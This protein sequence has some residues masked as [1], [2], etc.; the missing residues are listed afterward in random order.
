M[1]F[2]KLDTGIL[3]STLWVERECRELFITALLMAEPHE[4]LSDVPQIA[5]R[6]LEP[7]GWTVP[8]GWYGFIAAAGVGIIRRAIMEQ[9]LGMTAL[10]RLCA[11]DPE[12]RS[13][14]FEGR[15]LA[16]VDGGY[17]VLNYMKYRERDYTSAERQ[18]RYRLRKMGNV[19]PVAREDTPLR[20]NI[21]QA[22][23]EV[24]V[25]KVKSKGARKRATPL[26]EDFKISD[27]VKTW[28]L[29]KG[30]AGYLPAYFEFFIG[31]MSANG[32]TYVDW[33]QAFMNCVR[34]D[35]PG[36]RGAIAHVPPPAQRACT[37][38]GTTAW[39]SLDR[40]GV[41]GQCQG[42]SEQ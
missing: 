31:R 19:T 18:R 39:G 32:K 40:Y 11:P 28:A 35:W 30:Y 17:V 42:V 21:T 8:A 6:S 41:C 25:D 34:E 5:V 27:N 36:L 24:E 9:E 23:G 14:D 15:R 33:D 29:Q 1:A 4:F 37:K 12:S 26:P 38:C 20:R 10:E 13:S 3:N 22:E 2:V 16:R 7:T